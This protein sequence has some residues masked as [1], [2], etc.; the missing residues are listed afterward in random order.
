MNE[1]EVISWEYS[2]DSVFSHNQ[3]SGYIL[4]ARLSREQLHPTHPK[5][6]PLTITSRTQTQSKPVSLLTSLREKHNHCSNSAWKISFDSHIAV[7]WPDSVITTNAPTTLGLPR[8]SSLPTQRHFCFAA[9][10]EI[11]HPLTS[12]ENAGLF[13]SNYRAMC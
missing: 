13:F 4:N 12:Q 11:E 5:Q 10:A 9:A 7:Y 8:H 2:N 1:R 3:C 6:P